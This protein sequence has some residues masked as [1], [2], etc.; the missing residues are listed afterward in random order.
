M[1]SSS[2]Q[3]APLQDGERASLPRIGQ[4]LEIGVAVA[5]LGTTSKQLTG[6]F[7]GAASPVISD[8]NFRMDFQMCRV[9][10]TDFEVMY[11]ADADSLIERYVRRSGE[12]LH[13]VAFQVSDARKAMAA[14]RAR[15]VPPLA[16]EPVRLDNLL[17][18]FLPPKHFGGI[19]FEFIENLH[20]WVDGTPLLPPNPV[21]RPGNI[22]VRGFGA[23][24]ADLDAAMQSFSDLLG[25][26]NSLVFIDSELRVKACLSRVANVE[27]KLMESL[28]E[29]V[30]SPLLS[31]RRALQH[32][33][34]EAI[35]VDSAMA[36]MKRWGIRFL[37]SEETSQGTRFSDPASCHGIMF[38]LL[39]CATA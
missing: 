6:L 26:R 17:A 23:R 20:A 8:P 10:D 37:H 19:L 15:G 1:T 29:S 21:L 14:F 4:L 36:R 38:E 25:A 32:V 3:P 34:L 35:D 22:R 9:R 33:R 2:T 16:D 28:D 27:F 18:F 5:D 24:V 12:G 30:G 13:H 31:E 11:S 7:E 39:P